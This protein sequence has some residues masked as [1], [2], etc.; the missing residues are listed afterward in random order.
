MVS[1]AESAY[2]QLCGQITQEFN[3]CS[4]QV[5]EL[6]SLF[7]EPDF[8]RNDLASLLRSVQTHEKE[9]LHLVLGSS[10]LLSLI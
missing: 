2:Q 10:F 3:D 6:E 1:G 9:K 8:S 5:L 4:N 7:L